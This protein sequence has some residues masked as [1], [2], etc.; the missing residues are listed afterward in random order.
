MATNR[1]RRKTAMLA[2]VA[3]AKAT[4]T[5]LET[6]FYSC[7]SDLVADLGHL[8]EKH[9]GSAVP[10]YDAFD[11]Y[12]RAIGMFSAEDRHPDGDPYMNDEIEI[13]V[14]LG[15]IFWP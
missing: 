3:F 10:E 11:M 5:D 4:R 2:L 14:T 15:Q 12:R 7:I 1:D 13:N 6:D 9:G 8:A